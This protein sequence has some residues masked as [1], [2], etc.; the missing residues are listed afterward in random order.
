MELLDPPLKIT[1]RG[2]GAQ[3]EYSATDQALRCS[4]CAS[5][6]E[7]ARPAPAPAAPAASDE[8]IVPLSVSEQALLDAV[9]QHLASGALTPDDLLACATFTRKDRFYA[10]TFEF[11]GSYE[12]KWTASF[13]YDRVEH[14]TVYESRTEN[15]RTKQVP[16]TKTRTVTDWRPASG[17]DAGRFQVRTYAGERLGAAESPLLALVED[18]SLGRPVAFNA[19]Y[20]LGVQQEAF[21]READAAYEQ[22]GRA[23]VHVCIDAGVERHRQGDR[24]SDWHWTARIRK[25]HRTVWVPVCQVT[26]DYQGQAYQVWTSGVDAERMVADKLPVDRSRVKALV[27]GL[28]PLAVALVASPMAI[29]TAKQMGEEPALPVLTLVAA[30]AFAVWRYWAIVGHSMQ[31][32]QAFLAA[33]RGDPAGVSGAGVK[34]TAAARILGAAAH[35]TVLICACIG[36]GLLPALSVVQWPSWRSAAPVAEEAPPPRQA[37][38]A[39]PRPKPP[40]FVTPAPARP[41]PAVPLTAEQAIVSVLQAANSKDWQAVDERLAQMKSSAPPSSPGD[42]EALNDKAR[43]WLRQDDTTRAAQALTQVVAIA[44]DRPS[45]WATLTE[46]LTHADAGLSALRVAVHL[47]TDREKTLV[48]LRDAAQNSA[49]ENFAKLA[50]AVLKEI[51]QIPLHPKDTGAKPL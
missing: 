13:G 16:V 29:E 20:A 37:Q 19:S 15:G 3:Q 45:G 17:S 1:C 32:R 40:P 50:A 30:G 48:Y 46:V 41:A 18:E 21:A 5:V 35:Q 23:Q 11:K 26:Y 10:P 47:S 36:A 38:Q 22:R 6:T 31:R 25:Q 7:I 8:A 28:A 33:R 14:Y 27:W 51:D 9:Y 2:C 24:Q 42:V 49:S 39:A 12:A 34:P 4:Y 44:P 43:R